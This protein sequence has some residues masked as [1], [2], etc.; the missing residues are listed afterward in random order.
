M[1]VGKGREAELGVRETTSLNIRRKERTQ[2]RE[3]KPRQRGVRRQKI[4]NGMF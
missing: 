1:G 3:R 4:K 2:K